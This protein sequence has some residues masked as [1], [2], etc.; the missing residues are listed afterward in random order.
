MEDNFPCVCGHNKIHHK[1]LKPDF[2]YCSICYHMHGETR[3]IH[4]FKLDNLRYLEVLSE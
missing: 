1:L 3:S 4:E 2:Q